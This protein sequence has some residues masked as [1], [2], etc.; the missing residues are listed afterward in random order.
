MGR[1]PSGRQQSLNSSVVTV[2]NNSVLED[3]AESKDIEYADFIKRFDRLDLDEK[4]K[5]ELIG[6]KETIKRLQDK[7]EELFQG[8][9]Q[10]FALLTGPAGTGKTSFVRKLAE[11]SK[12]KLNFFY[13]KS[14]WMLEKQFGNPEQKIRSIFNE[15]IEKAPSLIYIDKIDLICPEKR[16]QIDLK[17]RIFNVLEDKLENLAETSPKVL[18]LAATNKPE[19]LDPQLR[20]PNYFSDEIKF[21]L[22]K[23]QD[24]IEILKHLTKDFPGK[25]DIEQIADASHCYSYPDL[26][27]LCRIATKQCNGSLK[28]ALS[29]FKPIAIKSITTPCPPLRWDDIGGVNNV[30]RDLQEL[31]IWPLEHRDKFINMGIKSRKGALLYG[32]PGCSKTMLA[33]ALATESGYNFIS[34]KGPELFSKY[35]GD[36]EAAVRKLYRNAREIAPCIIFFDEIDGLAANRNDNQSSSVGEKVVSTLLTELNGIE[37]LD[38]VFTIAAT[39]R[40]NKIDSALLR[41]GRLRPAIYIPLPNEEDRREI[42]KVHMKPLKLDFES[43]SIEEVIQ[44]LAQETAGYSGAEIAEICDVAGTLALRE[45]IE[46]KF[47][48]LDHFQEALKNVKPKTEAED[49]KSYREFQRKTFQTE[50]VKKK[51]PRRRLKLLN[52]IK[53]RSNSSVSADANE[54][55]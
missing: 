5:F 27:K 44:S 15:A 22:P 8:G 29:Q 3:G 10:D 40:P 39:N 47:I 25:D 2:T 37:P 24:R 43:S 51:T 20:K 36:S 31:V 48:K 50:P 12:D 52:F 53:R 16:S 21:T 18:V 23:K 14:S 19:L 54:V 30:K 9:K 6:C 34:V 45:N 28:S 11:Q 26:L 35:V 33:Q 41:P 49:L 46:N 55:A 1:R 17:D 7:I 42:F 32:P 38:D 13:L 4:C